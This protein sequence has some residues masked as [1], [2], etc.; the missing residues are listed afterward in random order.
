M[1]LYTQIL[2]TLKYWLYFWVSRNWKFSV[3]F[4][5]FRHMGKTR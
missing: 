1:G 5:F 4:R 3:D 2:N